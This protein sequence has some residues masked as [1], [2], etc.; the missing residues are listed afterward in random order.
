M[1]S[2][3]SNY[4]KKLKKRANESHVYKN[5]QLVGLEIAEMLDDEKHK[6][7]Y[8]KLVKSG[9]ADKLRRLAKSVAEKKSVKNK[10]AYFMWLLKNKNV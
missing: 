8:I 5:Y 6:S 10:G 3:A 7:L 9:E 4:L 1:A 2:V